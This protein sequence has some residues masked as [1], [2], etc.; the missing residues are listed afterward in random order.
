MNEAIAGDGTATGRFSGAL[1]PAP[2]IRHRSGGRC[3]TTRG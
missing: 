1:A 3:V 2:T